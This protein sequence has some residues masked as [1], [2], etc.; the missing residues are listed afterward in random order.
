LAK[1]IEINPNHAEAWYGKGVALGKLGKHE[2]A[3]KCYEKAIE[4]NPNHAKA[5]YGK[6]AALKSS[7]RATEAQKCFVEAK[8]LGFGR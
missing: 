2:E 5:W 3:L 8:K 6:G 7:G 1:A 4:I